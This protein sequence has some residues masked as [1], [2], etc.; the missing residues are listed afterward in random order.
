MI[1]KSMKDLEVRLVDK[2]YFGGRC[3]EHS[4]IDFN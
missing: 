1:E 2:T 4:V 3:F